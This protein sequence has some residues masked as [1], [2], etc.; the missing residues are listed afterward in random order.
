MDS[1]NIHVYL[2]ELYFNSSVL[3]ESHFNILELYVVFTR[4][5]SNL[6]EPVKTA[7]HMTSQFPYDGGNES[8][9]QLAWSYDRHSKALV[10]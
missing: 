8:L 2:S 3:D 9:S 5:S 1:L 4:L 7:V 6:N 10:R